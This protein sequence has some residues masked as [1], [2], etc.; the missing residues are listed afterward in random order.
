[1]SLE[2][3]DQ[4]LMSSSRVEKQGQVIARGE[5]ELRRKVLELNV[6]GAEEEAVVV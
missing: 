1:V 5:L 2:D 6:L 3:V 4:V